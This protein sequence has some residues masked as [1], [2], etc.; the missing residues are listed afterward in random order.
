[1]YAFIIEDFY[2]QNVYNILNAV[3][4]F[5]KS[6]FNDKFDSPYIKNYLLYAHDA[7]S[8][9]NSRVERYNNLVAYVNEKIKK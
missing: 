2:G 1:M 8:S 9:V 5:Y 7:V 3:C 4:D 6:Y